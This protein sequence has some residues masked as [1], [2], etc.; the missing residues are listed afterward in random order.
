MGIRNLANYRGYGQQ[1]ETRCK[2]STQNLAIHIG[3]IDFRV[4]PA[5]DFNIALSDTIGH[6]SFQDTG[7]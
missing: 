3:Q 5:I 6:E 2:L 4:A 1:S 7:I